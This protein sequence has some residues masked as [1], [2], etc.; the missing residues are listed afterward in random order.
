[1]LALTVKLKQND[2]VKT[3]V[4]TKDVTSTRMTGK[5]TFH[6]TAQCTQYSNDSDSIFRFFCIYRH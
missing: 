1:M 2:G 6:F 4:H 5:K 3:L